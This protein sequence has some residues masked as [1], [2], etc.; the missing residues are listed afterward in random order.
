VGGVKRRAL[1]PAPG[2]KDANGVKVVWVIVTYGACGQLA[3]YL[4]ASS[5]FNLS[6]QTI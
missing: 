2:V 6:P 3:R 4:R 1:G 5:A